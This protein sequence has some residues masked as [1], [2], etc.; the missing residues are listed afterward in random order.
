MTKTDWTAETIL[1]TSAQLADDWTQDDGTLHAV[2]ELAAEMLTTYAER[3]AA[4][5]GA[6][7]CEMCKKLQGQV[8]AM[9]TVLEV[10]ESRNSRQPAQEQPGWKVPG[11]LTLFP[12]ASEHGIGYV[13]GWN[14]CRAEMLAVSP[15]PPKEN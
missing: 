4:D 9:Q 14:D 8:D 10:R 6:V 11:A 5:E 2:R 12:N 15:T 3:I 7:P 13:K 1:N